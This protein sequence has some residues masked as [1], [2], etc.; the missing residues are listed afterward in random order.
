MTE[1]ELYASSQKMKEAG[2]NLMACGCGAFLIPILA[3][4]IFGAALVLLSLAGVLK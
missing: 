1:D 2:N 4:V 3:L